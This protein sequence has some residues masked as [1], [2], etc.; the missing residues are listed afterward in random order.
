MIGVGDFWP[1]KVTL[2]STFSTLRNTRGRSRI[3][4]Q[5]VMFSA[6][7]ISSSAP[8]AQN[9]IDAGSILAWA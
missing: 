3:A 2:V 8:A 5:A 9:A 1:S 7:L 4:R 6:T